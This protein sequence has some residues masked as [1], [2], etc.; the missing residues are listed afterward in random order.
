MAHQLYMHNVYIYIIFNIYIYIY[1]YIV[2]QNPQYMYITYISHVCASAYVFMCMG[3]CSLAGNGRGR[4]GS[5]LVNVLFVLLGRH[6]HRF[7][8]GYI[9][10]IST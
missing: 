6:W 4:V 5:G 8:G 3:K 9:L 1:R 10:V 2:L 7:R